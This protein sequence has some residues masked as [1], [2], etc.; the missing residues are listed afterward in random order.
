ML[1]CVMNDASIHTR[2]WLS[3]LFVDLGIPDDSGMGSEGKPQ[4]DDIR[5]EKHDGG[6]PAV[7][8]YSLGEEFIVD[9]WYLGEVA[10]SAVRI[11]FAMIRDDTAMALHY[12]L[13]IHVSMLSS[14]T[15]YRAS[16]SHC[17]RS[18]RRG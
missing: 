5:Q 17:H 4:T 15:K 10:S 9:R 13:N 11:R 2:M 6:E 3:F 12:V 1:I 7:W 16:D 18:D 14:P 8:P